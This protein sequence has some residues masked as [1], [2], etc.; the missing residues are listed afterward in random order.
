M[1]VKLIEEREG[2]RQGLMPGANGAA[3]DEFVVPAHAQT[4]PSEQARQRPQPTSQTAPAL[5]GIAS[6]VGLALRVLS[7]RA[8]LGLYH[9]LPI[10]A[11]SSAFILWTSVMSEPSTNQL[12]GSGLYALFMLAL[13]WLVRRR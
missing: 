9:L 4:A 12:I 1:A 11:L 2:Q 6:L 10:L 3:I 7:E 13:T 5:A 8:I